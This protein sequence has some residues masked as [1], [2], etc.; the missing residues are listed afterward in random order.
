M[1]E[2]IAARIKERRMLLG[3]SQHKMADLIGVTPGAVSRWER[4][5]AKPSPE[6]LSVVAKTLDVG[7]DWLLLGVNGN[8]NGNGNCVEVPFFYEVEASAGL[9]HVN[10][11]EVKDSYYPVPKV[12]MDKQSKLDEI[13]C[14]KCKGDSMEPVFNNGSVVAVNC[15]KRNVVDGAI[16]VLSV[17]EQLRLK[18]LSQSHKGLILKSYNKDYS[19]ELI[20]WGDCESVKIIGK[21]FYHSTNFD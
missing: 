9:G 19:D 2:S 8:G 6:L 21:V 4:S 11:N 10:D 16:Y 17:G 15:S 7:V 5:T 14:I 3:L 13:V 18:I 1:K 12:V 20:L